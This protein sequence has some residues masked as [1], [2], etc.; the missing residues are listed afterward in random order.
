[1]KYNNR[2]V[3]TAYEKIAGQYLIDEGMEILSYNYRC[4]MGEIDII[5][6]QGE[7]LVFCEVKYRR[8]SGKGY[9]GEAVTPKKQHV[10]SKC[11]MYYVTEHHLMDVPCRFDVV[12]IEGSEIEHIPN[13]FLYC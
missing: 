13:A 3:G 6:R 5:A 11:A 10:I 8:T 1:M 2:T 12:C 9:P 7:Y 4:R